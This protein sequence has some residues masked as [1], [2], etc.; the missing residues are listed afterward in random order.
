MQELLAARVTLTPQALQPRP[1]AL[2]VAMLGHCPGR[3]RLERLLA[4]PQVLAE[5]RASGYAS[6]VDQLQAGTADTFLQSLHHLPLPLR[7]SAEFHDIFP[8]AHANPTQYRSILAGNRAWL[9]PCVDDFF[10]NG[11]VKLWLVKVPE[12]ESQ[13]GFFPAENTQVHDV[14]TLRGLATLLII[15]SVGSIAFPDLERLQVPAKLPDIPRVRL[16][17]PDPQ[18]VPCTDSL[19]DDHRER[20]N[21]DEIPEAPDPL[22]FSTVLQQLLRTTGQYRPDWQLLLSMPLAYS[23]AL[24]T[25]RLDPAAVQVLNSLKQTEQAHRL[26]QLQLIFPYLR[27]P[28]FSLRSAVGAIAG[29]QANR[30]Q[31]IGVWA[32]IADQPLQVAARPYPSLSVSETVAFRD[33]PGLSV[34]R[35]CRNQLRL[36]DERLTVPALPAADIKTTVNDSRYDG[37]RSAEI[38]RFFGY[39]QR[40]LRS[41]GEQLVFNV[42]YRDPRPRLLMDRFFRNLHQRGALR[43]ILP[44][45]AFQIR[46]IPANEGVMLF[47]IEIAPALPIER[48]RLTFSNVDGYWNGGL[49]LG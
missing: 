1:A 33:K 17:N 16:D 45:D 10:A 42:D 41:L 22:L 47:E 12:S 31:R 30:A 46:Q 35:F 11:G 34:I 20:R 9:S 29:Q 21:D 44:E 6:H 18:F 4:M 43:G 37:Y 3:V 19:D 15:N 25:P 28:A 13:S 40:A 39:L 49:Y 8:D 2:E 14:L 27:G 38:Q 7:S 32:S 36:D 48:L 24:D 23:E 26:R 5:M